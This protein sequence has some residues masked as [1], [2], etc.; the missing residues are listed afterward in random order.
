MRL[1][2]LEVHIPTTRSIVTS[3]NLSPREAGKPDIM[4]V[5]TSFNIAEQ[6]ISAANVR[7]EA[8]TVFLG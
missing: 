8:A 1:K 4:R 6:Q 5:A 3:D 7:T 2:I